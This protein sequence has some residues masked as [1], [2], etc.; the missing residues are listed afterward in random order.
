MAAISPNLRC[1]PPTIDGVA[2][3]I[4]TA[5]AAAE[6]VEARLAGSR[7]RWSRD[8]DAS[9]SDAVMERIEALL[10]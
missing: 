5:T 10:G 1:A 9:F 3:A 8:W 4:A 6:D 7:V 2:E